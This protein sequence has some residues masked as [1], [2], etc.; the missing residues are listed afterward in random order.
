MPFFALCKS[1]IFQVFLVV[2]LLITLKMFQDFERYQ[3]Y[4]HVLG[5]YTGFFSKYPF[6]QVFKKHYHYFARCCPLFA[7][8]FAQCC[9]LFA[10]YFSVSAPYRLLATMEMCEFWALNGEMREIYAFLV[11]F[12]V[13]F[14][15]AW[16]LLCSS[17]GLPLSPLLFP[18][19]Q[20]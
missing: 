4:K 1:W 10:P 6:S 8:Y 5:S 11:N 13:I 7:P 16:N 14:P 2:F 15:P 17:V 3:H 20:T 18:C 19:P 9:P 12:G